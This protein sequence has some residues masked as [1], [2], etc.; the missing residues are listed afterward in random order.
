[1]SYTYD[2]PRPAVT[3]DAVVFRN[4]DS[5]HQILLIKRVNPPFAGMWAIPGGF[6][7]MD[8][9]LLDSAKRELAEETGIKEVP[10]YEFGVYG[11]V[12]RDPR[13]RTISIAY[14]GLLKDTTM[15]AKADDDAADCSWFGINN[16]PPLAFDHNEILK[17]AISF[18]RR[19]KWMP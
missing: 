3:V 10:L 19:E 7:E 12:G 16:L 9:E 15:Q 4:T 18:A 5:G 14:A 6:I 2:Y 8:E 13:H 1:M 17:D 11:T